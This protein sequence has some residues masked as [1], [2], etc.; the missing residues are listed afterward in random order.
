MLV[1]QDAINYLAVESQK[2]DPGASSHWQKYHSK[3]E[4]NGVKFLGLQGF[5]GAAKPLIG[6]RLWLTLFL[7]KK[8]RGIGKNFSEFEVID[9]IASKI[10]KKQGR[11]YDL[12]VLRQVLTIS[13]LKQIPEAKNKL[14]SLGTSCVIGD[15]FATL[16]TLLLESHSAKRIFLVNLTKTLLVDLWY[17]RLWMGSEKFQQSVNLVLDE[18]GLE[19][20]LSKDL[21]RLDRVQII[22]IQAADHE[23]IQKCPIDIVFKIASMQEMDPPIIAEYFQDMRHLA[24][25]RELIFYC[26]NRKDKQLPDGTITRFNEYPWLSNDQVLINEICP[27]HQQYYSISP[28]F[29]RSYDGLHLHKL[30]ILSPRKISFYE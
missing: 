27:W 22:A 19:L 18:D 8:F 20:A 11:E 29:Y 4:F 10:T 3:F 12:D 26:C 5:G 14:N 24:R 16:A 28:P 17:L 7:Q 2:E 25:D 13:F 21:Q 9:K 23:L 15:G 30:A 6:L 1:G